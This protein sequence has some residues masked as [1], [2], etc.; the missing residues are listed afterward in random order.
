MRIFSIR[1]GSHQAFP[2]AFGGPANA[3]N[4]PQVGARKVSVELAVAVLTVDVT[5]AVAEIGIAVAHRTAAVEVDSAEEAI[6]RR[7]NL[8]PRRQR[9]LTTRLLD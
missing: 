5:T 6:A 7:T 8:S 1:C 2:I 4:A 9:H 3:R